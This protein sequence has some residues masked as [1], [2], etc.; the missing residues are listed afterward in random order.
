V[1][2]PSGATWSELTGRVRCRSSGRRPRC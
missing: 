2:F 1:V